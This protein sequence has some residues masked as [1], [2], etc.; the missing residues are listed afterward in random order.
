M[1]WKCKEKK[2]GIKNDSQIF[3]LV[4]MWMVDIDHDRNR[5]SSLFC[6]YVKGRLGR[7]VFRILSSV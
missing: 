6:V 1:D 3:G 5:K 4:I 2:E 7:G